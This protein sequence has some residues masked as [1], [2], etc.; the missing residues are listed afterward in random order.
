MVKMKDRSHRYIIN[1]TM[2]R[3]GYNILNLKWV[4]LW[5]R[6]C[7]VSHTQAI[8]ETELMKKVKQHW[9]WDKKAF[10]IKKSV[11]T[12]FRIRLNNGIF[13]NAVNISNYT[14]PCQ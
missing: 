4:S 10:L 12:L 5:W 11:Y 6:L 1:R 9:G 14:S 8:S 3:H 13:L 7:A 2:P